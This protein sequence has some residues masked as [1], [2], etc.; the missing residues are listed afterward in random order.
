MEELEAPLKNVVATIGNFD[1]VHLGHQ[2][3]IRS[4]AKH[5]EKIGATPVVITFRPHPQFV[6]RPGSSAHLINT[7]DEKLELI[8]DLG[9]EVVVEEPFSREFSNTSPRDF[10]GKVKSKLGLKVLYLGYD[11]K[12]GKERSGSVEI[13][14]ELGKELGIEIHVLSAKEVGEAVSS[15]RIRNCLKEGKMEEAAQLLG[16][17]FFLRGLVWRGDGRGRTI[18]VPTANLRTENRV[19]PKV[20]VYASKTLWRGQ[21]YNSISN[22][23]F[24]P[25]FLG[26][27]DDLPLK[28]ETHLFEFAHDMYGDEIQVNFL[29]FIREE[30]KFSSVNS[31]MAQIQLD[32][33][34][35]RKV[36]PIYE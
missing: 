7:Y 30:K 18:G 24:N 9:I 36:F 19:Y 32:F 29:H 1:G 35:A 5:A 10:L 26:T 31:L 23:G 11:F 6:L 25:T 12:F 20:G 2:E 34:E 17:P 28:V 15:S 22:I 21:W 16:R 3:L 33:A 14:K 13:S 8:S 27:G 4:V